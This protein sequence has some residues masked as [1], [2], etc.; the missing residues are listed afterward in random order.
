MSV[1]Q[2][3]RQQA[4]VIHA[5]LVRDIQTRFGNRLGYMA[6]LLW[7]L[8]HIGFL[9]VIYSV[10]GRATPW[11][12]S[13]T[14][15]FATGLTPYMFF[16]YPGRFVMNCIAQNAALLSFPVVHV[17]D[18]IAARVALETVNGLFVIVV[19]WC[20]LY[21]LDLAQM[22][23]NP[24]LA[25]E[26]LAI[27]W[28]LL[29]GWGSLNALV[30]AKFP[31]WMLPTALVNVVFYLSS[32]ILFVPAA[33]P[34]RFQDI[35]W[36]NPTVHCVQL[37]REAFYSDYPR[38]DSMP[39]LFYPIVVGLMMIMLSLIGERFVLRRVLN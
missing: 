4:N 2:P 31:I 13:T 39:E 20:V 30:V 25:V 10:S 17:F 35:I 27:L 6:I 32:S 36:W 9:L 38:P 28:L 19:T 37:F 14:L 24:V 29:A 33:L 8:V 1:F 5:V 7:P 23:S 11:G 18:L 16:G 22:P 12:K 15:F 26:A 34:Q 3:L 21:V